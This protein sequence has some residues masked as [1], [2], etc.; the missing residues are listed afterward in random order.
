MKGDNEKDSSATTTLER[1]SNLNHDNMGEVA[2][3]SMECRQ[4][5]MNLDELKEKKCFPA[6]GSGG[7]DGTSGTVAAA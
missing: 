2:F 7:S 4:Q 6:T 5:Q 1:C 3:C